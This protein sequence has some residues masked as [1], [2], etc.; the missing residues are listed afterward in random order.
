M[1]N[2]SISPAI[3]KLIGFDTSGPDV[4]I[5][6]NACTTQ[7]S[8][9]DRRQWEKYVRQRAVL[10][11]QEPQIASLIC[12]MRPLLA[13]PSEG[14]IVAKEKFEW[15]IF[16]HSDHMLIKN[17]QPIIDELTAPFRFRGQNTI[18]PTPYNILDLTIKRIISIAELDDSWWL[19]VHS[20][21]LMASPGDPVIVVNE[22]A[23]LPIAA[24]THRQATA[25]RQRVEAKKSATVRKEEVRLKQ[26]ILRYHAQGLSPY[27]I[28]IDTPEGKRYLELKGLSIRD[29]HKDRQKIINTINTVIRTYKKP[30][31]RRKRA[32]P[33][34]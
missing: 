26:A 9:N 15:Q 8:N 19:W 32:S 16:G 2:N 7:L 10:V 25:E 30:E 1:P 18:T 29:P 20:L 23:K 17:A 24:M 27:R 33:Q 31:S 14:F 4:T 3:Q 28:G 6:I 5:T 22:P 34:T 11:Q 21:F 13:V 12:A